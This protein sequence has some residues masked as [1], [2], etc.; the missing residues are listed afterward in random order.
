MFQSRLSKACFRSGVRLAFAPDAMEGANWVVVGQ[1]W[2]EQDRRGSTQ[3]LFWFAKL[4]RRV[5]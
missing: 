5:V 3:Q 4:S 2:Q 1:K